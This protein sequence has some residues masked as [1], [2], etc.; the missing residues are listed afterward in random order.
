LIN[1]LDRRNVRPAS[2]G[3]NARTFEVFGLYDQMF[4]RIPSA[5]FLLEF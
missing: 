4:P 5:G 2:P 3:I 1:V